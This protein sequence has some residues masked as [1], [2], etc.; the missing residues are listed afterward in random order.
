M[1]GGSMDNYREV[2][3]LVG[4]MAIVTGGA[5]LIGKEIAKGLADFGANVVVA[6]INLEAAEQVSRCIGSQV[7]PE[8]LDI[9]KEDSIMG[10]INQYN[11]I[12]VWI[13]AAYPRTVDWG[14]KFEKTSIASWKQNVDSS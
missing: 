11:R 13:N 5:G 1:D 3:S 12:D 9:T 4:K 6:D 10:L 2:F 14:N 8:H 7:Q